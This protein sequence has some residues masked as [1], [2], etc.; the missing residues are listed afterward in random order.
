MTDLAYIPDGEQPEKITE[1]ERETLTDE[2]IEQKE[3]AF[4][5]AGGNCRMNGDLGDCQK[6]GDQ[7][8]VRDIDPR[9]PAYELG[10][11]HCPDTNKI[12]YDEHDKLS[13][14]YANLDMM[15]LGRTEMPTE[16]TRVLKLVNNCD[17]GVFFKFNPLTTPAWVYQKNFEHKLEKENLEDEA[18][19]CGITV[20]KYETK[21]YDPYD[22]AYP[23]ETE[24]EIRI[25]NEIRLLT[26]QEF[27]ERVKTEILSKFPDQGSMGVFEQNARKESMERD[28]RFMRE[29]HRLKEWK[30]KILEK[31]RR[32]EKIRRAILARLNE[33]LAWK[34]PDGALLDG[35]VVYDSYSPESRLSTADAVKRRFGSP[36]PLEWGTHEL[37]LQKDRDEKDEIEKLRDE[38]AAVPKTLIGLIQLEAKSSFTKEFDSEENKFDFPSFAE[39]HHHLWGRNVE[40]PE[41]QAA[42]ASVNPRVTNEEEARLMATRLGLQLGGAGQDFTG[43]YETKGFYAYNEGNYTGMAFF[44]TGGDQFQMEAPVSEPENGQYRPADA[45]FLINDELDN[46]DESDAKADGDQSV[47]ATKAKRCKKFRDNM[48]NVKKRIRDEKNANFFVEPGDKLNLKLP[49]QKAEWIGG[50]MWVGHD[51]D[52]RTG[53]NCKWGNG[54]IRNNFLNFQWIKDEVQFEINGEQGWVTDLGARFCGKAAQLRMSNKENYCTGAMCNFDINKHCPKFI[55]GQFSKKEEVRTKAEHMSWEWDVFGETMGDI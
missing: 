36:S 32:L 28:E 37:A 43:D 50:Q 33:K 45:I 23:G 30:A 21:E 7:I 53:K 40:T 54:L 4:E 17:K 18:E 25:R 29:E 22:P 52:L 20:D 5:E 6:Y 24:E 46:S 12:F 11:Q 31:E 14:R 9:G 39:L 3:H 44:G 19:H 15:A 49:D 47:E 34:I 48:R 8:K 35:D 16:E 13:S 41:S 2:Q 51:C 26:E 10:N 38:L 42:G 1:S 27:K 55:K